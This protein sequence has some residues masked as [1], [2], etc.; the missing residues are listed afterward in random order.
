MLTENKPEVVDITAGVLKPGQSRPEPS[1]PGGLRKFFSSI[2]NK[3]S[4]FTVGVTLVLIT[5][6]AASVYAF[7]S[8]E[9]EQIILQS[10][11]AQA[12]DDGEK[13]ELVIKERL[14]DFQP[15]S[16]LRLFRVESVS[17][18]LTV[19]QKAQALQDF[20]DGSEG[21]FVSL[22][23]IDTSGNPQ[24]YSKNVIPRNHS[25]ESY[26]QKAL[27]NEKPILEVRFTKNKDNPQAEIYIARLVRNWNQEVVGILLGS[28]NPKVL[29]D[30][31]IRLKESDRK[32]YLVVEEKG[33]ILVSSRSE[34]VGKP[35]TEIIPTW[36]S[37]AKNSSLKFLGEWAVGT[38]YQLRGD[39]GWSLAIITK[40][41]EVFAPLYRMQLLFILGTIGATI[42]V[43]VAISY[44]VDRFIQPLLAATEVVK[45]LGAG[46][47]DAR[48]AVKG[49]DELAVL[50]QNINS[51]A[52]QLKELLEEKEKEVERIEIARQEA[53]LE[54]EQL[55]REQQEAKEFL[56]KR[57]L[58]LLLEVDPVSR[59][60]LTV[61][62]KVTP[63]EIG[64]IADSYN[65]IIRSLRQIVQQVQVTAAS[66]FATS[67]ENE[68]SIR[69]IVEE[70]LEQ[71]Q[72]L[73]TSTYIL[74]E[75][76]ASSKGVTD[77]ARMAQEQV[78]MA[79]TVVAEG[80]QAMNR[81]VEGISSIRETV[82]ETAKKVKRLGEASQKISKVV[83]LI[84]EFASQTNLLAL[85][86][87]IEAARAGEA[88]RG[89][90]V[91]ADEVRSLAEQSATATA[92]IEQ[93]VEEIQTQTREVVVAMEEGTDQVVEGTKLVEES[94][95]K[96][97]QI[98][99]VSKQI[100]QLVR[101]IASAATEQLTTSQKVQKTV[102][103]VY[104]IAEETAQKSE[105]VADSF[106]RLLELAQSLQEATKQFKV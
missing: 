25:Q 62:A 49:E 105:S 10:Q 4:A 86:A 12:R 90:G 17:K 28:V 23:F 45:L 52:E 85:N 50:G 47:L 7:V 100:G 44:A 56:Q 38:P 29:D 24:F 77:R 68:E 51:L 73:K 13:L 33:N 102:E 32:D 99:A 93:L 91:V 15:L 84:S 41:S 89:F 83:N 79:T 19:Q 16:R 64:T 5:T 31:L 58:E 60:D 97:Q 69:G 103:A 57:A 70:Y 88:G 48:V 78:E 76:A 61:R 106:S 8:Y 63:D 66:V 54:A 71:V 43:T 39:L 87:A 59:G 42:T 27:A 22:Q 1:S 3:A 30:Q 37:L 98:A 95:Q 74:S 21:G 104:K 94:R 14:A 20:V 2:R 36:E 75:L 26:F 55:A 35:V 101:E 53:R 40:E 46:N 67:Q 11:R 6:A 92:E 9:L 80:D 18:S 96:L 34:L 81:T 72:G 65:A 82:S